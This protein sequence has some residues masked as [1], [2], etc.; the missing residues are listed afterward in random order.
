MGTNSLGRSLLLCGFSL[1]GLRIVVSNQVSLDQPAF[2]FLQ[3]GQIHF[4]ICTNTFRILDKYILEV[5][6]I[7]FRI[8]T[9]TFCNS[10]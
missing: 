2:A 8:W 9:N 5:G 10:N 3:F 4:A 1:N 6:Q 7:Y